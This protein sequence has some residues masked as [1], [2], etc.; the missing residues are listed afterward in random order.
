MHRDGLTALGIAAKEGFLDKAELILEKHR[1]TGRY[2][3]FKSGCINGR[4]SKT[5]KTLLHFAA[6]TDNVNVAK[7]LVSNS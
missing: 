5:N 2:G 1:S 6:E 3:S 4:N 7:L